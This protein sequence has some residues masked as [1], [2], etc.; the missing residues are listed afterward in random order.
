MGMSI[1][2]DAMD[3]GGKG[4]MENLLILPPFS[5]VC[6]HDQSLLLL[7]LL[8]RFSRVLLCVIP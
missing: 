4:Y 8:S 7:L 6:M 2:G 5:F 3:V 1:M